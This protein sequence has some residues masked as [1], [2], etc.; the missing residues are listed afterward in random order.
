M[1]ELLHCPFCGRQPEILEIL[2]SNFP[3]VKDV[4]K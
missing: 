2:E 4:L 1:E 3:E